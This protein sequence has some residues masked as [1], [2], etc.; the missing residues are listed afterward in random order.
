MATLS[1]HFSVNGSHEIHLDNNLS[2][3]DILV[4]YMDI[5]KFKLLLQNGLRLAR[6][7][8][9]VKD[10]PFEG[11]FTE[12]IYSISHQ[13][14]KEDNGKRTYFS[15]TLKNEVE[16]IRKHAF[17]S[18]WA[19]GTSESVAMWR[20][21]GRSKDSVAI[22][23]SVGQIKN[24]I[25]L[26]LQGASSETNLLAKYMKKQIV[27]IRYIDHRT[28]ED[29]KKLFN[30]SDAQI[31]FY[32]NV[33]YRYEE[34]IRILFDA[35]EQGR[36]GIAERA[37]DSCLIAINPKKIIH[38]I[39]VSPFACNC[40]FQSV[41]S[42]AKKYNISERVKWS[43]LKFVPGEPVPTTKSRCSSLT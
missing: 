39:L 18:S 7:D 1:N 21:Y 27:K 38:E 3:K 22:K 30:I 40:F 23:T 15:E 8:M 29:A 28:H 2:E 37:G 34:E 33:G 11:E 5:E 32:K 31:L 42:E 14:S 20:L 25:E 13:V 43:D 36:D 17:I 19:L 35:S 16:R 12:Q 24:E 6:A 41:K 9:F 26:V 4:R 10:D